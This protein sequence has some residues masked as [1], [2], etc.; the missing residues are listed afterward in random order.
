MTK[1]T[2]WI[3]TGEIRPPKTGEWFLGSNG[4]PVM[5]RFDFTAQ[6]FRILREEVTEMIADIEVSKS[7]EPQS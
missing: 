3:E 1:V 5:A 7:E 6:E 2:R 4:Y